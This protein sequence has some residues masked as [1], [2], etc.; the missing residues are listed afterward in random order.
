[1]LWFLQFLTDV[2]A[3]AH[4]AWSFRADMSAAY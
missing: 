2:A 4:G 1:M 3:L